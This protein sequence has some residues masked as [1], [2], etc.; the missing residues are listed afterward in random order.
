MDGRQWSG[1]AA[2][3]V[4]G[5]HKI[6]G[7]MPVDCFDQCFAI[8]VGSE[9]GYT[10]NPADP[11]NWTGGHVGR[12]RCSGTKF[13][14]SAAAYPDLDISGLSEATAKAIY[15]KDFWAMICG[16]DLPPVLALLVFD[17]AINSGVHRAITWLQASVQVTIDGVIGPATL[18]AITAVTNRTDGGMTVCADFLAKRLLFMASLPTWGLFGDGWSRRLFRLPYQSMTLTT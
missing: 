5:R 2:D 7:V 10:D 15:H 17:A 18:T 8:V 14:I 6:S 11:G 16:D 1:M 13:G 9:G 4:A 3:P 12:G